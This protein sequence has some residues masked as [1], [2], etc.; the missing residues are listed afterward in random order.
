MGDVVNLR[1]VRKTKARAQR[2]AVAAENRAAFGRGKTDVTAS[3][4]ERRRTEAALDGARLTDSPAG[5]RTDRA[6]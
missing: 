1:H 4:A 6:D 3:E 2:E 5:N